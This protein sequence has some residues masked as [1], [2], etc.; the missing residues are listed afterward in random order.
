MNTASNWFEIPC[1]DFGRAVR[2]YRGIFGMELPTEDFMNEP[3]MYF[4]FDCD[5]AGGSV[6]LSKHRVPSEHG[7]VVYL[8]AGEDIIGIVGRVPVFGGTVLRDVHSIGPG[9]YAA[10]FLDS[11]GNSVGV[12]ANDLRPIT[13][14]VPGRDQG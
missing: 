14:L 12:H 4:P 6:I 5:A 13:S 8:N 1:R 9:G 7:T 2:F 3:T 11:E 10:L